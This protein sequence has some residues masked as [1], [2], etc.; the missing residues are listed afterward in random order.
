M[1]NL[2]EKLEESVEAH[3]T[4]NGYNNIFLLGEDLIAKRCSDKSI[5]VNEYKIAKYLYRHG[6]AVP[7]TYGLIKE[8]FKPEQYG[9][10]RT[11]YLI[12]ER[13]PGEEI[14]NLIGENRTEAYKQLKEEIGKVLKLGISPT[15][16]LSETNSIFNPKTRK[17]Y[18]IDFGFWFW[19]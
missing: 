8:R 16:S 2:I 15:D 14:G 7:K 18:L 6:I 12:M 11:F 9:L 4:L 5:L 1:V 13:I 10:I 3:K 17:L 19:S